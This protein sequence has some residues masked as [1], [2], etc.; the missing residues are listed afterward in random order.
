M[1]SL[2]RGAEAVRAAVGVAALA[3]VAVALLSGCGSSSSSEGEKASFTGSGYPGVD[4]ANT[5]N[6]K[7]EINSSNVASLEVA[8]TAPIPGTSNFGSY[9]S[10]P[11][12]DKG[13]IYSQDLASNV[14]A[15]SLDSGEVLWTATFELPDEGPNGIS[16]AEGRVYGATPTEAF[17]LDQK[18]GEQL[19][20]VKLSRN[21]HEGID[22]APGVQDGIVYVSTVP[23]NA[24]QLYEGGGAGILWA[25]NAKTG[26]KLWHFNTVPNDLWGNPNLNSGGGVWYPPAF[27][28]KGSMYFGVGNPAP[29]PGTGKYPFGSSRAGPNLYTDSLVKLNAK[30][31]KLDWFHQVTPHD[32]YDW[33]FQ[34]PP[35]LLEAGGREIVAAAGKSGIVVAADPKTGKVLWQRAVGKHNGHDEDGLLAMH[36]EESNIKTPS[37]VYPGSLGGV[38]APMSTDG[39]SLFVPIVNNP[40]ELTSGSE[41]TEPGPTSGEVVALDAATGKVEWKQQLS[42]PAFGATTVVNDLV[43]ATNYEGSVSA[44]KAKSGQIVWREKLPAGTN[45]GV[46]ANGNTL[47]A[48]AGIAA[49]EGQKP[50]IVA[51][52]L[53]E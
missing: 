3:I 11:V 8:W 7:S 34:G 14:Q 19:W 32:L 41:K 47:I 9:A 51:Y 18:T 30:T 40:I 17:A 35:I 4:A 15:L 22:M 21:E 28:G 13:V 52:R 25:L 46:M 33:D 26:K 48:P 1:D 23:L 42:S 39:S 38:I 24:E 44:F 2:S 36:G 10:T 43:F 49:A 27:D 50:E 31:G 12:I 6:P 16:V 53:G 37:T 29:F 45:S 20:S 5:R